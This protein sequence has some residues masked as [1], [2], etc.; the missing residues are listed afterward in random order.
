MEETNRISFEKTTTP[1]QFYSS[2]EQKQQQFQIII[3]GRNEEKN[4][5]IIT[6]VMI[7]QNNH[8]T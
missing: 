3:Y 4:Q 2:Q 8:H 1:L 5:F 7:K 6:Y